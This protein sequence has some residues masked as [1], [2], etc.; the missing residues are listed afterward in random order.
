[1]ND[2]KAYWDENARRYAGSHWASWGDELAIEL[3]VDTIAR[4]ITPGARVLDAGCAN[5]F[6]T[7]AQYRR[8]EGRI[9]ITGVD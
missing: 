4:Y 8:Q 3:E 1:M 7:I 2:T 9:S 6:S 5:G